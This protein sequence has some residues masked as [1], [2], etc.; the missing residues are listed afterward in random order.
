M[1]LNKVAGY[2]F[3]KSLLVRFHADTTSQEQVCVWV[4]C[5]ILHCILVCAVEKVE[6]RYVE[7]H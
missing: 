5:E 1:K 7:L 2:P 6:N 3:T 4:C